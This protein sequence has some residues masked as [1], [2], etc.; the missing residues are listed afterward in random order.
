M[1]CEEAVHQSQRDLLAVVHRQ[2]SLFHREVELSHVDVGAVFSRFITFLGVLVADIDLLLSGVFAGALSHY[3][4]Y[5]CLTF[6]IQFQV[7]LQNN[8]YKG[9]YHFLVVKVVVGQTL[10]ELLAHLLLASLVVVAELHSGVLESPFH[11][12]FGIEDILLVVLGC[13]GASP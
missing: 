4:K 3:K 5:I 12:F 8:R 1:I 11:V 9:S 2:V 10:L 7:W 13:V 6:V